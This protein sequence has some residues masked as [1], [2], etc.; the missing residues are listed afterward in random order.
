MEERPTEGNMSRLF[1][2][3]EGLTM[4]NRRETKQRGFCNGLSRRDFLMVSA[5]GLSGP[6]LADWLRLKARASA[7]ADGA[8]GWTPLFNGKDLEG[9]DIWLGRPMGEKEIVGLNKD[10]KNIFTV[11]EADGK[12]AVRISG[13]IPGAITSKKEHENYHLRV[14]FKW[15][16]KNWRA[17]KMPHD[18]GILYHCVGPHGAQ[19]GAWMES[20]ECEVM[21]DHCGDFVT[22]FGPHAD[23]EVEADTVPNKDYPKRK[24]HVY[25][26]GGKKVSIG[27][28]TRVLPDVDHEKPHGQWNTIDVL[29][30]G[31][32]SVFLVNGKV[33]M[34]ATN[35]RR[36]V[37][38]KE[39]PLTSGKI[40][41]ISEWAEL[42]YRTIALRPLEKIPEEYLK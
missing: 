35:A 10:P 17:G 34:R 11:V 18:G 31:T 42:Y 30:V 1:Y 4:L 38:G 39:V 21:K 16:E 27:K 25:K 20:L 19:G 6:T 28:N 12:P 23:L 13:E 26:Q 3:H 37:D 24:F 14:E 15:G 33:N 5:L 2:Y 9:W 22:I 36:I 40:Q 29:T 32:S 7:K 41:I 8:P